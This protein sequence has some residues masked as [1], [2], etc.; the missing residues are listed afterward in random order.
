MFISVS[1]GKE[2]SSQGKSIPVVVTCAYLADRHG[3]HPGLSFS[4]LSPSVDFSYSLS[5][6]SRGF[7]SQCPPLTSS[8]FPS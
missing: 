6:D 1:D 7:S 4:V 3:F 2:N 8:F 5:A